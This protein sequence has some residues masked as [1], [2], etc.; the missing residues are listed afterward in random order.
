MSRSKKSHLAPKSHPATADR[1]GPT[2][3][4]S[5]SDDSDRDDSDESDDK[6][7]PAPVAPPP[8]AAPKP[9]APAAPPVSAEPAK[10]SPPPERRS[11]GKLMHEN[12]QFLS[13]VVIGGAGL[14]ATSLYQW[15]NS[16]LAQQ[17]ADW[18]RQREQEKS[19]NEWRIERA[20]ILAQ[21]LQ[22][23][24]AR[25]SDTAEQRYGV[26]LSLTRGKIIERDL[27]V[28]YAL[29]LGKDNSEDMR[30]VLSNI[31]DK[32]VHYYRRLI[33]AYEPTCTQR[34]GT[35]ASSMYVCRKDRLESF[36]KGIAEAVA[37]DLADPENAVPLAPLHDERYVHTRLISMLGTYDEF[38]NDVYDRRQWQV[39]DRFLGNST[40]ARLI[41][42][43]DLLMQSVE[44]V[45]S[46]D[47][48]SIR[49][50]FDQTHSWLH[51]YI[52]GP[53]CDGDCRS[54]MSSVLLSN[55]GHSP[56]HFPRLL[57][58]LLEGNRIEVAPFVDRLLVRLTACQLDQNL[59]PLLRDQVLVPALL[60]QVAKP[61]PQQELIDQLLALMQTLPLPPD[62]SADWKKLQG[63]LAQVT[64]GRHPKLFFDRHK[65][66]QRR[67]KLAVDTALKV[68][69]PHGAAAA[70]PPAPALATSAT[71]GLLP[72]Y[73]FCLVAGQAQARSSESD[74]D[75]EE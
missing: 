62:T 14:I 1:S 30:S 71:G 73:N 24:T 31:E 40:G 39:L 7:E 59:I 53:A 3:A 72:G 42:S 46:A 5:D 29:E 49:Q 26:L 9:S 2:Q 57:Q 11:I 75:S 69:P 56:D 28:S 66:E 65:E 27:A 6:A 52:A 41:G 20:K 54:R 12:T 48:A 34:Y 4:H 67:R 44:T 61:Q 33:E 25:G 68:K 38:V 16:K 21:N 36:S 45:N 23:L 35:Q 74:E 43:F 47:Q 22:T 60:T 10:P 58:S 50:R 63:L 51:D 37:D 13:S 32:D 15:N 70:G 18:Q 17:Q 64:K 19:D 55:L 8:A